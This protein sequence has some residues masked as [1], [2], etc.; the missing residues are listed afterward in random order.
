[1]PIPK[2]RDNE[3]RDD[4]LSRCMGNDTMV[5]EYD[6]REQ[7]YAI[8]NQI[9]R[10]RNKQEDNMDMETKSITIQ[11]KDDGEEKGSFVAKIAELNV[12]DKDNDRTIPGAFPD[13]RELLVSSY[14]HSSWTA[15]LPV[16]KAV[17]HEE[18]ENVLAYGQFN[19]NSQIGRDHYET[20]KFSGGLQ[21]WSYGYRVVD[22]EEVTE[23]GQTIR[24]LKRIE[25]VEISP[26]LLGAGVG[27]TTLSIKSEDKD[28]GLKYVDQAETTLAEVTALLER[29][30]SLADLRAKEGRVL[31]AA[32]RKRIQQL[33]KSLHE[34]ADDL[35]D[36]LAATEPD[37]DKARK[38][39]LDY[40]RLENELMEVNK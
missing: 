34:V 35:K 17:I 19:L 33:L 2:P 5:E 3:N 40:L 9:W 8:C 30:R 28:T 24:I 21:E 11:L 27:T 39:V 22:S 36:L 14:Q 18:G 32:N 1:M 31:S 13:G 26:V 6:D 12:I 38:L 20:V 7:R 16:G 29:T 10:D 37:K 4:F 25:P 15:A 23:D